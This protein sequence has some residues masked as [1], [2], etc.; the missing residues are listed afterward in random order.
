MTAP[1]PPP[2]KPR[3]R[4]PYLLAGAIVAGV[5][6][7]ALATR[8][9]EPPPPSDPIE[10]EI[11]KA[12][13]KAERAR[14]IAEWAEKRAELARLRESRI[15]DQL[16]DAGLPMVPPAPPVPPIPPPMGKPAVP[17]PPGTP[18][19]EELDGFEIARAL[20][21]TRPGVAACGRQYT[22]LLEV[23]VTIEIDRDGEVSAVYLPRKWASTPFEMC[24]KRAIDAD[25]E[26][27]PIAAD[28]QVI[29]EKFG[30][31]P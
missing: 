28:R 21:E 14:L 9:D 20:A 18:V 25:A 16:E 10:A 11:E 17:P 31:P 26:F 5:V 24:V 29:R 3:S 15:Q 6:G 8:R 1:T 27:P 22:D 23:V 7:V 19:T 12:A 2:A 30:I 4:R 13:S